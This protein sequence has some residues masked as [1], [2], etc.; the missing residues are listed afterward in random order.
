MRRFGAYELTHFIGR[1]GM[2]EVWRASHS[3]LDRPAA[4]KLIHTAGAPDGATLA[5]K[6]FE[7]EAKATSALTS[8][9][10]VGIYDYGQT[11]DGAFYYA[12]ELLDGLDLKSA[13][14]RFGPM[15][16]ERVVHLLRQVCESLGEAHQAGLVHRDI[17]PA[18]VFICKVGM[19]VDFAKVL[20]F[21]LV[22]KLSV[23]GAEATQLTHSDVSPGS[24]AFMPPEAIEG[25][26]HIDARSDIYSVGCLAYW[27]LTGSLVFEADTMLK[28]LLAH[29]NETPQ[30]PSRLTEV[31]VPAALEALIMRCLLKDKA[32]RPQTAADVIELLDTVDGGPAWTPARA[33]AWWKAHRPEPRWETVDGL[34]VAAVDEPEL[35]TDPTALESERQRV[36][37]AL[38]H[39]FVH[40]HIGFSE[41]DRRVEAARVAESPAALQPLLAD[42]ETSQPVVAL[43]PVA[44]TAV[45]RPEDKRGWSTRIALFSG[46]SRRGAWRAE[47]HNHILAVFGGAN[48]DFREADMG[49]G[50]TQVRVLAVFG[51][52][53]IV[54]PPDMYVEVDGFGVFGGFS[55]TPDGPTRPESG[56]PWLRVTG[57]AVFGGVKVKQKQ[58]LMLQQ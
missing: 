1:G 31:E 17:K 55:D 2:G 52:A 58:R 4:I 41:M 25:P 39:K 46:V 56:K 29:V 27:L 23:D 11:D 18:N 40:S 22:K 21:G 12:M 37:A 26:D 7:R 50:M 14:D 43:A 10:T 34:P 5:L 15:P 13:V 30:P 35:V 53:E 9:H 28:M 51:G 54:V 19:T 6:R 24:P 45:A 33:Q 47:S 36:Q 16:A 49:P 57:V 48:L 3:L 32:E 38:R 44:P 42:L 20:D 8:P